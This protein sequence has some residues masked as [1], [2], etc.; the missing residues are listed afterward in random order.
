MSS[1]NVTRVY[2]ALTAAAALVLVVLVAR[3]FPIIEWVPLAA[4]VVLNAVTEN[5]SFQLPLSGSVSLS[6]A[7][8]FAAM[9]YAGPFGAVLC[10]IAGSTTI[11]EFRTQKPW[12]IRL[13]NASQLALSAGIAGLVY[14]GLGGHLLS[15][16]SGLDAAPAPAVAAAAA[17]F[18]IN[19]LLVGYIVALRSNQTLR[20]VMQEQGFLSYAASM[21]VLGLLGLLIAHLLAIASWVGLLLLVLPFMLARRT[22]RV[23]V[24]LTEA[25]TS[26]VR[27]LVAAIEAKDPYTRGHSERVAVLAGRL[28][29]KLRLPK[30]EVELVERAA[31]LHDVGKIGID[32]DTLTSPVQLSA[33]EVRVIRQHPVIGSHLVADVEFLSDIVPIVRHHH[34]RV[35]GKGY[36]DG[37]PGVKIPRLARILAIADA[38]DA[39]TSDRAYRLGMTEDRAL[40]EIVRVAGTQLDHDMA[41]QFVSMLLEAE[42]SQ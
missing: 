18:L 23:S 10:A 20:T 41:G 21:L 26:T 40:A 38:Y 2:I 28:A 4:L 31:L 39:M 1:S 42:G 22:F 27:S 9:V 33:E 16:S 12:S 35:D 36:P 8:T 30:Q 29:R 37:L 24:E 13:F 19:I 17:F 7:I 34:E 11:E 3:G 6:F 25:Y 5:F 15:T 32:L 14:V